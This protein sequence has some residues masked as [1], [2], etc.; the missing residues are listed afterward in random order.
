[1]GDDPATASTE[2]TTIM[3]ASGAAG[4]FNFLVGSLAFL[5]LIDVFG[6]ASGKFNEVHVNEY[7]YLLLK[8]SLGLLSGCVVCVFVPPSF[9]VSNCSV[10]LS[11]FRD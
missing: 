1:M 3:A 8:L 10:G 11:S 4:Y 5:L 9:P 7:M 2:Q 6:P